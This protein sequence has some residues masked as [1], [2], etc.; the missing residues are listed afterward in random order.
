MKTIDSTKMSLILSL[1]LLRKQVS[2]I[3]DDL[4]SQELEA[5]TKLGFKREISE[6]D[7]IDNQIM[8]ME[9]RLGP[10]FR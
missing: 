8:T 9:F 1:R 2:M 7:M 4:E 10:K 3:I 5:P 6:L